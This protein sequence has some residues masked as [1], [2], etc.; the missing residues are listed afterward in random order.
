MSR[1]DEL[2]Y[3]LNETSFFRD[4]KPFDL[5]KDVVM[6]PLIE[7]RKDIKKIRRQLNMRDRAPLEA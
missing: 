1:T 5:F 7:A 3:P 4:L 2:L 6:P